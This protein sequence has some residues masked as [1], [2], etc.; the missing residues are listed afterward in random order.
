MLKIEG[1]EK[2]YSSEP[3]FENVNLSVDYGQRVGLVGRNG[4][5][6]STLL[7][8]ITEQE[9][10]DHG[11]ISYPK[12]YKL[13]FL[14]QHL[15]FKEK[16]ILGVACSQMHK[17]EDG[18]DMSYKAKT[19]LLG[20]GFLESQFEEAPSTL[21][22]G[23]Q[24]RLNLAKL[25]VSEP[26]LLLLDE[27]TNYLDIL[28]VRWLIR[29]LNQW[30]GELIL[31][32]HDRT[33]MDSVITHTI[34]IHRGKVR[35]VEGQ[36]Q[37]YYDLLATEEELSEKTRENQLKK[38]KETEQ[39]VNRFRAQAS[40]AKAVQSRIKALEKEE[41][42]EK[43]EDIRSLDF[44]FPYE[45]FRGDWP[46]HVKNL[47]FGYT[48]E[49]QLIKD[50]SF[51]IKNGDRIAI[52]GKNGKGKTT[53]LNLIAKEIAAKET[54]D[55]IEFADKTI[56]SFFGQTNIDRLNPESSI[57]EEITEENPSLNRSIVRSICGSML[58]SGSLAEKKIKVL[59][60]G[61]RARVLLGKLLVRKANLLLLDEPTN[62]L[63]ME[64]CRALTKAIKKYEGSIIF[65]SHDE[66]LLKK[67]ATRLVVFDRGKITLF[68]GGYK[69]FLKKVGW[70]EEDGME[71]KDS[72][73]KKSSSSLSKI[74][75]KKI[76]SEVNQRRKTELRPLAREMSKLEEQIISFEEEVNSHTD[77]MLEIANDPSNPII[78]E[79]SKAIG[80]KQRDIESLFAKLEEASEKHNKLEEEFK[81]K[82]ELIS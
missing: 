41:V 2:S 76:R 74:E 4:H 29:F 8:I 59:S 73:S 68:D 20:L 81:E 54:R 34:G 19:I 38:R 28:S 46:F 70:Q 58:F 36:T 75:R 53:L 63:D 66:G 67:V 35:K 5:G 77:K 37:K 82:L 18:I 78:A 6:K 11:N 27:P 33:F 48:K 12:D 44:K 56:F 60:G 31:I 1:L 69:D 80:Q 61:E 26:N 65:V 62:H 14:E 49:T 52:I 30:Q 24:I 45:L 57:E 50:L 22:G 40:K 51:S 42:I 9:H 13:G 23:Y 79:L 15:D 21:S 17:S 16:T 25:L 47:S 55:Q 72:S 64:S 10:A 39:F 43:L 32:T 7:K 3:L 71:V